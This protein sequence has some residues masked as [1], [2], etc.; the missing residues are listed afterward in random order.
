MEVSESFIRSGGLKHI[1]CGKMEIFNLQDLDLFRKI[2][3]I[4]KNN[5]TQMTQKTIKNFTIN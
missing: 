2:L 4:R 1:A 5:D 3:C